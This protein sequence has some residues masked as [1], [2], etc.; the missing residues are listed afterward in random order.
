MWVRVALVLALAALAVA[1]L[2]GVVFP[3]VDGLLGDGSATV[4]QS[5]SDTR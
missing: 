2:F 1:V 4:A 3:A 5:L